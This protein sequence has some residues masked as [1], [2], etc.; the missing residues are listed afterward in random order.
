[1]ATTAPAFCAYGLFL[2]VALLGSFALTAGGTERLVI[3]V[4]MV[5]VVFC[6]VFFIIYLTLYMPWVWTPGGTPPAPDAATAGVEQV[7]NPSILCVSTPEFDAERFARGAAI[8]GRTMGKKI[9]LHKRLVIEKAADFGAWKKVMMQG[10]FDI[11]HV[12]AHVDPENGA[13]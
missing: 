10:P 13:I 9:H 4:S 3:V 6:L 5:A 11:V 2:A 8:V 7:K 12:S 1:A